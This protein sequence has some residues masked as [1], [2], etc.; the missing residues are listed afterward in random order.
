MADYFPLGDLLGDDEDVAGD[1]LGDL[2]EMIGRRRGRRRRH[3]GGGGGGHM[4]RM[5]WRDQQLAPGVAAPGGRLQ[6]LGFPVAVFAAGTAINTLIQVN[7][8]P[9][10]PFRGERLV[11][12]V[13]RTAGAAAVGVRLVRVECGTANQLVGVDA[14]DADAFRPDAF[15]IRMVLDPVQPGVLV[16]LQFQN[17]LAVPAGESVTVLASIF[18]QAVG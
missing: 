16:T 1:L 15:G 11:L 6:A 17:A 14:I 12:T 3:R 18:G 10:R 13:L 9:Q 4:Q 2:E 5:Q 7:T 8:N